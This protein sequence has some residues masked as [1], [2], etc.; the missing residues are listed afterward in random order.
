MLRA[1]GKNPPHP[2]PPFDFA[3]FG[4]LRVCDRASFPEKLGRGIATAGLARPA[5][6]KLA[7]PLGRGPQLRTA[8]SPTMDRGPD[9]RI[10]LLVIGAGETSLPHGSA[11]SDRGEDA[12]PTGWLWLGSRPR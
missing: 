3:P 4:K 8:S 7:R 2:G 5:D 11:D 1:E 10:N 6:L 9:L 12:A